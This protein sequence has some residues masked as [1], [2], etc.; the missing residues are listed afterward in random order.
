MTLLLE[1][2]YFQ[3]KKF[4]VYILIDNNHWS[5]TNNNI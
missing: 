4:T 3:E 2:Y 1:K 5:I